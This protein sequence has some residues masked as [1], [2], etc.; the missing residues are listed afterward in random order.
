[1]IRV[2]LVDGP[3]SGRRLELR[4]E[5]PPPV[6]TVPPDRSWALHV[7]RLPVEHWARY[8]HEPWEGV[9]ATPQSY[10]GYERYVY[11]P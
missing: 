10:P 8:V 7:E 6:L 2:V 9:L 11:Q 3:A 1:M 5:A 4:E